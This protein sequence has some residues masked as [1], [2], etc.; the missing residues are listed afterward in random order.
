LADAADR[1]TR[2]RDDPP[3]GNAAP[4]GPR[5]RN[6]VWAGVFLD[7]V[8]RAGV[9]DVCISPGSRSTPLVLACARDPRFRTFVHLDE[10]SSAF[11]ALGV[12]KA[13]GR[14]ALVITTSGTAAA[15]LFPAVVEAAQAEVPL[16]IATADRPHRLRDADANQAIDQLRLFGPSVRAFFEVAP[17]EV[18]DAPLRHLRTLAARSVAL[19]VGLP[20]GPVHLNFPFDKPLEP[21][22]GND[23]GHDASRD[24]RA[25]RTV[26]A[27][28]GG[29]EGGRPHTHISRRRATVDRSD[30]ERVAKLL[31]GCARGLVL[32]GPTEEP[33]ALGSAVRRLAR[34]AGLP[35]LADPLSGARFGVG[36]AE[37][38]VVAGY[39]LFL[40]DPA[41]RR[42][43]TPDLILRVG[44]TPTSAAAHVLLDEC[45]GALQIV[46]DGGARWKD[47]HSDVEEYVRSYAPA[48]LEAL[49]EHLA[50]GAERKGTVDAERTEAAGAAR[51]D[52]A[53]ARREW[54][55]CWRRAEE[56][57]RGAVE[58]EL[59]GEF[60]EG[61]VLST[62][63][64]ALASDESLFVSSSMPVRDLDAFGAPGD[65]PFAV[66]GNRGA[67]GIDGIV[68]TALGVAAGGGGRV[69]AVLGD[70]AFYHDMN[71]LLAARDHGLDV[72]FVVIHNDGG[73]IFHMLPIREHEPDFTP[74]F[75]TPHGLDFRHVARLYDLP[76][77]RVEGAEGLRE[78]LVRRA[79]S[80]SE[81]GEGKSTGCRIIEVRTDREQNRRRHL[82]A[83]EAVR[84]AVRAGAAG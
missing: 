24:T 83:V 6:A 65:A 36:S 18:G 58:V 67:S 3:Q 50:E 38:N 84:A 39:D 19:A 57:T 20:A 70:I 63:V 68:S 34:V 66:F 53:T 52:A 48:F 1:T 4:A 25:E 78:A 33:A 22:L 16:L 54:L 59:G 12:G 46:I 2:Q 82:E 40:R 60:F 43:M 42:E 73:G 7:E 21:P 62:V 31:A 74:F 55:E 44:T 10:R 37:A 30:V 29:R 77:A 61:T 5:D 13:S 8:A 47:H 69:T 26:V 49:S 27:L 9:R 75:A 14:P 35:L 15:N 51:S 76:Y 28:P 32:A 81:D 17:P 72:T 11:F 71:G 80:S 41:I 45:G 23:A 64:A 79:E 56:L